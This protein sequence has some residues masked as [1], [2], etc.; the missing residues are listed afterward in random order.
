MILGFSL[1]SKLPSGTKSYFIDKG[2]LAQVEVPPYV[3]H[4][5][6][7]LTREKAIAFVTG[8]EGY[9]PSDFV[10]LSIDEVPGAVKILEKFKIRTTG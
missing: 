1:K 2:K 10:R 9:D 3:Y 4:A 5:F 7:P 6:W 8:S